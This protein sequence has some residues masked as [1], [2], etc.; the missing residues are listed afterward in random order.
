M[1]VYNRIWDK[2]LGKEV[3]IYRR[4]KGFDPVDECYEKVSILKSAIANQRKTKRAYQ[5]VFLDLAKAF[6]TVTHDS[7]KKALYR[8]SSSRNYWQH[9]RYV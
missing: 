8:K 9:Y 1:R 4:Q 5:I 2:R 3:K 6:D 7:I